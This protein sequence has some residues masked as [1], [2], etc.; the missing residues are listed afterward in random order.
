[1]GRCNWL[2]EMKCSSLS[3]GEMRQTVNTAKKHEII[4]LLNVAL[5]ADS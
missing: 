3:K 1:M 4:S 2:R 5:V